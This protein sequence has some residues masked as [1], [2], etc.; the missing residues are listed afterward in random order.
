M[1]PLSSMINGTTVLAGFRV[2]S[3]ALLLS[4]MAT[5]LRTNDSLRT[6]DCRRGEVDGDISN[7]HESCISTSSPI[8]K[9]LIV[10]YTL[11]S[12]PKCCPSLVVLLEGYNYVAV[13]YRIGGDTANM[14]RPRFCCHDCS[15]SQ[16]SCRSAF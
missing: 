11:F 12:I 2:I 3:L 1:P 8:S 15:H 16:V 14:S 13:R 4:G 7:S 9:V 10:V 5:V 6:W